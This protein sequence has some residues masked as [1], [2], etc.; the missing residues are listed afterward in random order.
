MDIIGFL[1]GIKDWIDYYL[2][3]HHLINYI[4]SHG[5][6]ISALRDLLTIFAIIIGGFWA[7]KKF[8]QY[9]ENKHWIQ[10]DIGA[11]TIKLEESVKPWTSLK[12]NNLEGLKLSDY[13]YAIEIRFKFTN[14]GNTRVKIYNIRGRISTMPPLGKNAVYQK[15]GHLSLCTIFKSGN[16]VPKNIIYYY[17][18]PH[19]EQTIT[20]L[21]LIPK[22]RELLRV[23]GEFTLANKRHFSDMAEFWSVGEI[24]SKKEMKEIRPKSLSYM[25]KRKLR[26][27][28]KPHSAERIYVIDKDGLIVKELDQGD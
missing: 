16:V 21:A 12:N 6:C 27:R 2:I 4:C 11:N 26:P 25:I 28:L 19:V 15:D 24:C 7:W 10:F 23:R 18:E 14:K 3:H 17:I 13:S 5:E 20:F 8:R 1:G 9:R 22:P